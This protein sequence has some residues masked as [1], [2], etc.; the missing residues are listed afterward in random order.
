MTGKGVNSHSDSEKQQLARKLHKPII[1]QLN[2]IQYNIIFSSAVRYN[3]LN[4][5]KSLNICDKNL[6]I[7]FE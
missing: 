2:I 7:K 3:I 6:D 1:E 4:T 5:K